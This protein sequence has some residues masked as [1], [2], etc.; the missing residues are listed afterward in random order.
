MLL[1]D[2]AWNISLV[3]RNI[4]T[5]H[6]ELVIHYLSKDSLRQQCLPSTKWEEPPPGFIKL[7]VD[8]SVLEVCSTMGTGGLLRSETGAWLKGFSSYEGVGDVLLA[9]LHLRTSYF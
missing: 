3:M 4:Y 5:S 9:E 6:D 7:N 8:G 1:S 2:E